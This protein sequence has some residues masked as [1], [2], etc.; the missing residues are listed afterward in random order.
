ML[1]DTHCHLTDKKYGENIEEIL[2]RARSVGVEKIIA[3]STSL[4]EAIQTVK[5]ADK[6]RSVYCL[7]GVHPEHVKEAVEV[8]ELEKLIRSSRKVVGVGEIGLDFHYD[9]EKKTKDE[10]I[11][12]FKKQLEL[13]LKLELPV[14][15]HTRDAKEETIKVFEELKERNLQFPKGVFHC[16]SGDQNFL[17]Y[18]LDMGFYVSFC[19]NITYKTNLN[20][21]D[22]TSEQSRLKSRTVSDE[23]PLLRDLLKLV[24]LE[25]LLLE[26]DAPYLSPEPLRGRLNEPKNVKI[27]AKFMAKILGLGVNALINQATKNSLC[28]FSLEN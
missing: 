23:R 13:A 24:P 12:L 18:V 2:E 6:Y 19:G 26:T 15:I 7:V 16:W 17:K 20:L 22:P 8:A 28:L 25:R 27:T 10:Q 4:E 9:K 3:P 11:E 5:L 21:S 14:A 1:I